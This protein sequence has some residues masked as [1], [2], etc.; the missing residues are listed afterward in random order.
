MATNSRFNAVVSLG[1]IRVSGF[2]AWLMWLVIH[3]FYLIGF[4]QRV[5]TLLH[6]AVSFLGRGRAERTVTRQQIVARRAL[7]TVPPTLSGRPHQ[8]EQAPE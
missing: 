4:K 2:I 5:T 3:I 6:W 8:A 1:R 7:D